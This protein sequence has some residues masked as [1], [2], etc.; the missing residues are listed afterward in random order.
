MRGG[1]VEGAL[2]ARLLMSGVRQQRPAAADEWYL[3]IYLMT[4][5][6]SNIAALALMR[7]LGISRKA[8]WLLKHKL[9]EAMRQREADQPLD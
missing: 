5:S 4:Q 1:A 8:A 3:A 2:A 9:M 7:Q 6:K